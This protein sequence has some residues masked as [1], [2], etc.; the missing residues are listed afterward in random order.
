MDRERDV[1]VY[2][3]FGRLGLVVPDLVDD[4]GPDDTGNGL[5]ISMIS[6]HVFAASEVT[7]RR[8][9]TWPVHLDQTTR[10]YTRLH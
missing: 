5:H 1:L 2:D 4:V 9:C 10:Y 3:R 7:S 8:A 6:F